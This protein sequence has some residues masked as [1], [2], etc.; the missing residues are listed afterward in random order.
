MITEEKKITHSYLIFVVIPKVIWLS[1]SAALTIMG[2]Q[3]IPTG[4]LFIQLPLGC[5]ESSDEP[6][7]PKSLTWDPIPP[8]T[9]SVGI[10]LK[11]KPWLLL[12]VLACDTFWAGF[13]L[14]PVQG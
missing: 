9:C 8:S 3:L 13:S 5:P 11:C 14:V 7:L 1:L 2:A 12:S 4:S 10:L 6:E